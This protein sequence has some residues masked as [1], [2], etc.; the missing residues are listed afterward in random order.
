MKKIILSLLSSVL[1]TGFINAQTVSV[2][3]ESG[4]RAIE[5]GN[6]WGFG[7][8]GYTNTAAQII[9][10]SWSMRSNSPTNLDPGACWIKSP[11]M[12]PGSGNITL[13]IK[14]EATSAATIR[15]VI[16]SYIPYVAA[17]S[18]GEG[19]L[20]RFDS[21][22]YTYSVST[23][24]PTSKQSLSFA[25]PSAIA[26]SSSAYKIQ[27]SFVGTGGTTRYNIDDVVIPGTYFSDP[28]NNCLPRVEVVD[29]DGDGVADKDDAYP[30]D[31]TRAYNNYSSSDYGT[32]LF[33]D[34]WPT[35]GD[36]DFNDLVIGYRYNM[37]TNSSNKVV[38]L[39]A[40]LVVRASGATFK[41]GF[42]IQLDGISPSSVT[43]VTNS[44]TQ[45]SSWV[46]TSSNGTEANQTYANIIVVDDASRVL[47]STNGNPITNT[48]VGAPYT[49][50]DTINLTISFVN[51]TLTTADIKLN[52]YLIINQ[53]RSREL[54]LANR[55][56]TS[57]AWNF[58]GTNDDDSN[59]SSG[60]YYV[61]KSNLPWALDVPATIPYPIEGVNVTK[62]F[63]FLANWAQSNGTQNSDWYINNSGNWD[64]GN[65]YSH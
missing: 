31:S 42:G 36:Y 41:N 60:R 26:N 55:Q 24:L 21:I 15:R 38:E 9:T 64:S 39:K 16:L 47:P 65:M 56:P 51:N 57:L 46:N 58:F 8:I 29:T 54:H 59:P 23:P 61:N 2:N 10:G 63:L 18:Y 25:I 4:N 6:C 49:T 33:E 19:N 14:F 7:S 13:N 27:L 62:A 5:Q 32:Y 30:N 44:Q 17:N 12:K 34:N 11:W 20:T 35:T 40:N 53:T 50:P 22:T 45:S 1:I 37:V 52:P 3:A 43:K 28:S 48:I